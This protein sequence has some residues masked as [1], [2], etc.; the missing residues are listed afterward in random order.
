MKKV[1]QIKNKNITMVT[2]SFL[3]NVKKCLLYE[4]W[5]CRGDNEIPGDLGTLQASLAM[6]DAFH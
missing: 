1:I 3:L 5:K 4:T 6:Q 2:F